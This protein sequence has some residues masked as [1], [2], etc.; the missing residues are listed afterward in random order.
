[1]KEEKRGERKRLSRRRGGRQPASALAVVEK[2]RTRGK[3][4]LNSPELTGP[5][6]KREVRIRLTKFYQKKKR[7]DPILFSEAPF[8]GAVASAFS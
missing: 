4:P 1:M 5:L 6:R 2:K 8:R 7:K 3:K